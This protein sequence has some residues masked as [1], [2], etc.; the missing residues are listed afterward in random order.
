MA[1]VQT[2]LYHNQCKLNLYMYSKLKFL[3]RNLCT[4]SL[5][6]CLT[7]IVSVLNF[8]YH[9]RFTLPMLNDNRR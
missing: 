8:Y 3:T 7:I 1:D 6:Q 4:L 5:R 2:L 9:F